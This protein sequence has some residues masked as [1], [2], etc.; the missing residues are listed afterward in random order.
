MKLSSTCRLCAEALH[1][2]VVD[3]GA[4]PLANAYLRPEQLCD[5]ELYYPLRIM[6]CE[7][8]YLVQVEAVVPPSVLFRDYAYFSSYSDTLLRESKAFAERMTGRL[9]LA[10]GDRVVEIASNDGYQLQYFLDA[11]LDVQGIE[12]ADTVAAAAVARGI[13]TTVQYFR[14]ELARELA[15]AGRQARLIVAN[16]VLAHVPDPGDF[17]DGLRLLL[18]PGGMISIQFHHL[19]ALVENAQFDT[20]YH[21]HFQYFSLASAREAL[22]ARGLD[23]VDVE[24]VPA[25]GGSLRLFVKHHEDVQEPASASVAGLLAREATAGLRTREC[26]VRLAERIR[27]VKLALL[28]FLV[29]ARKSGKSIVAYGAAAKGNTLLNFCGVHAD[30]IDYV[31][32]RN[33]HKQGHYMPG[34]RIPIRHPQAIVETKPD[35]VL[36]LPWNLSA[37]I[38]RQ[39]SHVRSWGGRFVIPIPSLR[40]SPADHGSE[41]PREILAVR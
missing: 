12:P 5:A 36:I 21:E 4:T 10:P 30:L 37:E 39:M 17:I 15:A 33:P 11:G 23:V 28:G 19:L 6:L 32:D 35:Y 16:N 8:C 7:H 14:S 20:I 3:L 2:L 18:A 9:G 1:H 41:A 34:S 25:Q 27:E 31:V 26:Y 13:P 40:I 38:M 24:E 22:A 29:S